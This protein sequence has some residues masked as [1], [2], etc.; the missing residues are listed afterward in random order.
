MKPAGACLVGTLALL[1]STAILALQ[2]TTGWPWQY[3][4]LFSDGVSY[5][6]MA[7]VI[8][9]SRDPLALTHWQQSQFPPGYPAVL[10]LF[11]GGTLDTLRAQWVQ[12]GTSLAT[13]LAL[14]LWFARTAGSIAAGLA[15]LLPCLLFPWHFPWA[16]ELSSE[17]LFLALLALCFW[18]ADA[19]DEASHRLW[20]LALL[21]G[22]LC[23]VRNAGLP[24]VPALAAWA[25]AR[26]A[27]RWRVLAA[28]ALALLPMLGWGIFRA[29]VEVRAGYGD[30]WPLLL[31][32][33]RE[34]PLEWVAG[35]FTGFAQGL[36]PAF[37][38]STA[39]VVAGALLL[40]LALPT[41]WR[42]LRTREL[43]AL[44]LTGYLPLVLVW[45][46]PAESSRL[47][48]VALPALLLYAWRSAVALAV[49]KR[50]PLPTPALAALA[51]AAVLVPAS[52]AWWHTLRRS[53]SP[54]IDADLG[55]YRRSAGWFASTDPAQFAEIS[56]RLVLLARSA[57]ERVPENA[58]IYTTQPALVSLHAHHAVRRTPPQ[59][60]D[61]N[62]ARTAR[63]CDYVIVSALATLQGLNR[64]LHPLGSDGGLLQPLLVSRL[65]DPRE[66]PV[67]A[68]L[69]RW[70]D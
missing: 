11:G 27:G 3:A 17:P 25:L 16:L 37:P 66:G 42:G 55:S 18:H 24:L 56:H 67:V 23:L 12:A 8:G 33:L 29:S 22:L 69:L 48:G 45:P 7:D 41:L 61:A 39:S 57:G 54:T 38:A 28:S 59:V 50:M 53:V 14:A 64:P 34:R 44:F 49:G 21:A 10:S 60:L 40:A 13:A 15:L 35:Q 30:A 32:V 58:C 63:A 43:P 1:G 52:D 6:Y 4:G 65:G 19:A 46:Y 51:L 2:W 70:R 62:G 36:S 5:L 31:R 9:G 47:L 68:A 20:V 26:G